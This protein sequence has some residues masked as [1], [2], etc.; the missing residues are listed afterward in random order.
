MKIITSP[1]PHFPGTVGLPDYLSFP[2]EAKWRRAVSEAIDVIKEIRGD[3]GEKV[4]YVD[5]AADAG[6]VEKMMP[7]ILALVSEWKI[8]G[9]PE[10]PTVDTFP[11]TPALSALRLVAWIIAEIDAMHEEAN[12]VPLA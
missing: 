3:D 4:R 1:V 9:I 11:A 10:T 2:Q 5:I 12:A 6:V 8:D 7:T